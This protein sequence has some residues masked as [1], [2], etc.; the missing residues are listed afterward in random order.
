VLELRV[1]GECEF[2]L[3]GT[4]LHLSPKR[5]A[6]VV[7]LALEGT[8]SGVKRSTLTELLWTDSSP[9]AARRNL[10]QELHRLKAS[11]LSG[12]LELTPEAVALRGPLECDVFRFEREQGDVQAALAL[13]RGPLLE[14]L[15]VPGAS[16]FDEWLKKRRGELHIRWYGL[17][18][19]RA[20]QLEA[21]GR[22]REALRELGP[23]LES[24][25]L[26]EA[27]DES[28]HREAMRLHALLG[29]RDS[30]LE[31]YTRLKTLLERELGVLPD[32][33]TQ[34]LVERLRGLP[35]SA[36]AL[37]ASH[38]SLSHPPLIGREALLESLE[39]FLQD[40]ENGVRHSSILSQLTPHLA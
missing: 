20:A 14:G 22:L 36:I 37:Q 24:A 31:R 21:E 12:L 16:G 29:E 18:R 2:W 11:A 13:Y 8:P 28:L 19:T 1:L 39:G 10:R 33:E 25:F 23:L 27:P 34:A 3:S 6:L 7:Y 26:L 15:D 30:A 38:G 40:S 5:T 35:S 4:L 9:E 17:K 32:A